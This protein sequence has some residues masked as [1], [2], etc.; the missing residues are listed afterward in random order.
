MENYDYT[1]WYDRTIEEEESCERM[2]DNAFRESG[3]A[4]DR[5]PEEFKGYMMQRKRAE[6]SD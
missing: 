4:F 2:V 5:D 1:S 6:L 3:A